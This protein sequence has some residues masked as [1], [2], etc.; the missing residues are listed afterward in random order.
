MHRRSRRR[1]GGAPLPGLLHSLGYPRHRK[2][3]GHSEAEAQPC[4]FIARRATNGAPPSE[5]A[6]PGTRHKPFARRRHFFLDSV[7]F[8][9]VCIQSTTGTTDSPRLCDPRHRTRGGC[10]DDNAQAYA[11]VLPHGNLRLDDPSPARRRGLRAGQRA[12]PRLPRRP[13]DPRLV[14]R[15]EG[16][17]RDAGRAEGRAARR[18]KF[19]RDV[20][21]RR[22][23]ALQ[24]VRAR[25]RL[26]HRLPRGRQGRA[27]QRA[28]QAGRLLRVPLQGGGHLREEQPRRLLRREAHRRCPE[29]RRLPRRPRRPQVV[30]VHLSRLLPEH[31]HDVH[32]LPRGQDDHRKPEHRH[33]GGGEAVP[34]K[35]PQPGHRRIGAEQI[36]LLHR[37]PRRPQHEGPAGPLI[38]HQQVEPARDVREVP[39][40]GLRPLQGERARHGPGTRRPRRPQLRRL[41]RGAR[42]P[43]RQG[44]EFPD[45][46][47]RR[48][49]VPDLPR[50]RETGRAVRRSGGKGARVP[51]EL[52][53]PLRPPGRQDRRELR[54][55]PRRPRDLP[56]VRPALHGQP[57]ESS[58]HLR[59][60]PPRRNGELRQREHPRGPG[61]HG[62][63]DQVLGGAVLHLDDRRGDRRDGRPQRVRLLPEDAGD[64]PEAAAVAATRVRAAQPFRADAAHSDPFD[65]LHA[66]DHGV[67]PEVQMVHPAVLRRGQRRAA[68]GNPPRRRRPHDRNQHLPPLLRALHGPGPRPG[69]ADAPA[70]EGRWRT[71]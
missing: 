44:P 33:P 5:A 1:R 13:G 40:R 46:L 20:P 39:L 45:H 15:G 7:R 36:R 67:R 31:R 11:S 52:P 51:A 30:R 71:S 63:Q 65:L 53:R 29:V 23:R 22:S 57:E 2:N 17:Q 25:G 54:L 60:M 70:L 19:P 9:A 10:D 56:L 43:R 47:G 24:A 50:R 58:R 37:L 3:G 68:R 64:L 41:P 27:A 26:L 6:Q 35:H 8:D 55:L 62:G 14:S 16:L 49:R 12:V 32:P 66:G 21:L 4:R 61:R 48:V 59:Q 69:L 18:G 34:A 42:R 28:T 38:V